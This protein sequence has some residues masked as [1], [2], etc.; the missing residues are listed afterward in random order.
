M[1]LDVDMENVGIARR[2]VR[3]TFDGIVPT[4]IAADL[5]LATSELVTNAFE[6]SRTSSVLVTVH[7]GHERASVSVRSTAQPGAV[8]DVSEWATPPPDQLSGRGLGIVHHVADHVD[9]VHADGEI[10]ITV[11][12]Q[13]PGR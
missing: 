4:D 6:H 2:F 1:R 7:T 10:E 11:H 9:V 13:L 3:S 12:R 5:V 8:T